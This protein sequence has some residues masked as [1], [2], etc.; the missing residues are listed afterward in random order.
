MRNKRRRTPSVGPAGLSPFEERAEAVLALVGRPHPRGALVERA[1][2]A[3]SGP[4][5][6]L[7]PAHRRGAGA[8]ELCDDVIR[9]GR[10][11][12]DQSD[13]QSDLGPEALAGQ[14]VAASGP[15]S[16]LREHE[17]RDDRGD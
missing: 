16:D 17:G 4:E 15:R 2:V 12:A 13:P 14:D 8:E 11:L 9:A 3:L 5:A 1:S 10:D 7:L 6:A